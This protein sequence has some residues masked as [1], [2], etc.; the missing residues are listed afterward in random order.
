[1][2]K[3]S[4]YN[5]DALFYSI[6]YFMKQESRSFEDTLNDSFY[7]IYSKEGYEYWDTIYDNPQNYLQENENTSTAS[8]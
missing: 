2:K 4:D 5:E 1:M 7:W 8:N 3:D 6:D